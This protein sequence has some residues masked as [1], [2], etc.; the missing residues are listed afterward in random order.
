MKDVYYLL[1]SRIVVKDCVCMC[2]CRCMCIASFFFFIRQLS[3]GVDT[4]CV[5]KHFLYHTRLYMAFMDIRVTLVINIITLHPLYIYNIEFFLYYYTYV[6]FWHYYFILV[7]RSNIAKYV[8]TCYFALN[9]F[10]WSCN[11]AIQ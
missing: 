10:R 4:T 9:F 8:T 2:G 6:L 7:L 1:V 5:R 3:H 11:I